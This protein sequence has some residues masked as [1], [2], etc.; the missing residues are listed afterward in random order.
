MAICI[1]AF[2]ALIVLDIS[3]TLINASSNIENIIGLIILFIGVLV[4]VK[5]K[6]LTQFKNKKDE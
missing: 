2:L 3:Y 5:T 6:C 4:S 1:W